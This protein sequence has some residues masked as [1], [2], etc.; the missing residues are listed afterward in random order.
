MYLSIMYVNKYFDALRE[1]RKKYGQN[2]ENIGLKYDELRQFMC[3]IPEE[4]NVGRYLEGQG[5][6]SLA[7]IEGKVKPPLFI[8][9]TEGY[10]LAVSET[11]LANIKAGRVR[12]KRRTGTLK[13][14]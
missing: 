13:F 1:Q 7:G 6:V 2:V 14:D 5:F 9:T 4:R 3:K 12:I 11:D 8:N 10:T